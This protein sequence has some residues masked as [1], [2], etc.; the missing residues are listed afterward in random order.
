ME[1][2]FAMM[3]FAFTATITPGPNNI[4]IMTSGVNYGVK[5]SLPHLL[6]ICFGFPSMVILIGLGF[7]V[8]FERYP[9]LH[10]LIKIIGIIYLIYLAWAIANTGPSKMKSQSKKPMSFMKAAMFQWV[11]PKAWVMATGAVS[12]YT[13]QS[14]DF[15]MQVLYITLTF[16]IVSFP[17]VG[18][19]LFFGVG[20]RKYLQ[21]PIH[22]RIFNISMALLLILSI[23]PVIIEIVETYLL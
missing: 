19:W 23:L 15:M 9:L 4:M 3:L 2:Y 11:N 21:D 12:A 8:V 13:T 7:S 22:Y 17:C 1:M 16:F 20:L 14:A 10:E 6:G 5:Q 18:T